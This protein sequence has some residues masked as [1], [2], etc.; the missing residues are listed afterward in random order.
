MLGKAVPGDDDSASLIEQIAGARR[1][2]R[3]RLPHDRRS[4]QRRGAS[5]RD[6][7]GR[8]DAGR[9]P[10]ASP[11]RGDSAGDAPPPTTRPPAA[12][13]PTEAAAATLPIGATVGPA[14]LPVMPYDLTFRGNFFEFADFIA[15]L[16]GMVSTEL[17]GRRRRRPAAD[18]RRLRASRAT[19]TKGFPYLSANLHVTTLRRPGRPGPDRRRDAPAGPAGDDARRPRRRRPQ[20]DR[21]GDAMKS[22]KDIATGQ[23][24]E[25]QG[26]G[27]ARKAAR[28]G[29]S[30]EPRSQG[31]PQVQ[32]P[33]FARRSLPRP[34]RPRLLI[35]VVALLVAL[36]AVP[37]CSRA[38]ASRAAPPAPRAA[39]DEDAPRSSRPCSPSR[40]GSATTASGS[41][42]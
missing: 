18:R 6:G 40:S 39:D 8:R 16:D 19:R 3:R 13:A 7:A 24:A 41:R 37:C 4:P 26:K 9:P 23:D 15:E 12:V 25:P 38:R 11:R 35:P 34:A 42:R 14:G 32:A 21:D 17:E 1:P 20:H 2:R 31:R 22:L 36:V 10:T 29:R 28:S 33:K 5:R 30:S 27:R